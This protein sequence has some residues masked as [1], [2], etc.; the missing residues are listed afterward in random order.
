MTTPSPR[1]PAS[2]PSPREP[3][4]TWPR[5]ERSSIAWTCSLAPEALADPGQVVQ[6]ATFAAAQQPENRLY[7]N[8]LGTALFRDGRF[9]AAQEKLLQSLGRAGRNQGVYDWLFLAMTCQK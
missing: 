4:G 1:I 9:E 2:S 7:V 8:T 3:F 5:S 6:L